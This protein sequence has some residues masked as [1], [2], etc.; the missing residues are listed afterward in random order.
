MKFG[1]ATP[2]RK[3]PGS[4]AGAGPGAAV[5]PLRLPAFFKRAP[6]FREALGPRNAAKASEASERPVEAACERTGAM[7]DASRAEALPRGRAGSAR[8]AAAEESFVPERAE[9]GMIAPRLQAGMST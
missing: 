2:A 9:D 6:A 3:R 4:G 7:P 1:I 5:K 8:G